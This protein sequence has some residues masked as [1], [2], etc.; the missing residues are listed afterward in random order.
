V[1]KRPIVDKTPL[2]HPDHPHMRGEKSRKALDVSHA[3]GSS[4]HAW[5]KAA[6]RDAALSS[7]RIIPTCVGKSS[8]LVTTG[9]CIADHP[10]MR[11]EKAN[12]R[13]PRGIRRGS[14]PHAWG[15]GGFFEPGKRATRIIPTCVGKRPQPLLAPWGTSDHPHMRGEK[16]RTGNMSGAM[17]GSSPHAWGKD[18]EEDV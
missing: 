5:G 7:A 2:F 13:W 4:P 8:A 11:G 16:G 9:V 15:K 17:R 3:D 10:H 14:S 6:V 1:G 18:D 12:F